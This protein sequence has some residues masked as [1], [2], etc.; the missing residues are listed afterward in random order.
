M[1]NS[2]ARKTF[3]ITLLELQALLDLHRAAPVQRTSQGATGSAGEPKEL[4]PEDAE[5]SSGPPVEL[6]RSSER[7]QG[8]A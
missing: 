6:A 4:T 5:R 2:A 8:M 3:P 1:L 7:R